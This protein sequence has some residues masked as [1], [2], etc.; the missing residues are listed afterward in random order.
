MSLTKKYKSLAEKGKSPTPKCK[1]FR[2]KRQVIDKKNKSHPSNNA[3]HQPKK[4]KP[5]T[6]SASDRQKNARHGKFCLVYVEKLFAHLRKQL[7][8]TPISP[9]PSNARQ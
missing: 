3:C 2:Q 8:F 9:V 1:P 6:K 4:L 5:S 7:A